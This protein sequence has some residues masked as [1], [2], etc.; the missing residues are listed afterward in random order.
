MQ[1]QNP[2]V[3]A[4]P[5]TVL[6]DARGVVVAFDRP[7]GGQVVVLDHLELQVRS[8]EIVAIL[9]PSGCGKSTF[10]RVLA[11][12]LPPTEGTV[13]YRG[14]PL[15]GPNPGAA[16][17]FQTFALFPW[18]TVLE[19]VEVGLRALRVPPADC[20]ARAVRAIDLIGLDGFESA[21]PKELS[22]GGRQR[23]GF[24]RALVVEPDILLLDEA[25]SAL[26]VLTAENLRT[27]LLEL[28]IG[29]KIP[30]RAMVIVTHSIEEA[31]FLAD[32]IIV[33]CTNPA[34]VVTEVRP[35]M[36]HWRDRHSTQFQAIVDRLYGIL[37][38]DREHRLAHPQPLI[39]RL[40]IAQVGLIAGLIEL[41]HDQGGRADL[42]QLSAKLLFDLDD[43]LPGVEAAA[44]L[45]FAVPQAG[46]IELTKEG[47]A[48]AEATVQQKKTLFREALLSHLVLAQEIV[49]T[50]THQ[51]GR[52][53]PAEFFLDILERHF[54]A[55]EARR[56][57]EILIRWGR[58]AEVFAYD[59][60]SG[61]LQLE[62][63][64]ERSG[65]PPSP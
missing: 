61:Y 58:Y 30:T 34:H 9:G 33:F 64:A 52:R 41:V 1:M 13:L 3:I 50:L 45:G 51:A 47:H 10:L 21:Y 54:S 48:F 20:R 55:E 31:V 28:W 56:Q 17:V 19:N 44:L 40:P 37:T 15:H 27:D 49:N 43:L 53:M 63:D 36:P 46:D 32:R 29:R 12:L 18:L 35:E 7:G 60:A 8:G 38:G 42:P 14:Q 5:P 6:L 62:D 26:D 59:E 65:V 16:M 39:P 4:S 57:L 22:G 24:A 11:G 2:T 23:V 25:F